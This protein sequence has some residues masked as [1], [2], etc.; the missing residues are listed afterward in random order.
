MRSVLF[1]ISLLLSSFVFSQN[2]EERDRI[3]EKR[4]E[5]I[6]ENIDNSTIDLTTYLEDLY[7]YYDN[8]INLNQTTFD[9]LAKL[10]ILTDNQIYGILNYRQKYGELLTIYELSA[11]EELDD[12]TIEMILPFVSVKKT[13]ISK[14]D[15]NKAISYGKHDIFLRYQ[16]VL[17]TKAGYLDYPDSVLAQSP[18]KKYTGSPDKLYARYRYTYKNNLSW[19][20]TAEKDAGEEFFK[21][22]NKQG[23]DFYSA[24]LM[25]S[26]VGVFQKVVVGDFQANFGQGLT[27]WSGFNMSKTPN[28]LNV[29]RYAKGLKPYTSVNETNFLRG[30]GV[31]L[32]HQFKSKHRVDFTLFGSQK[33]IDANLNLADTIFGGTSESVSSFQT[34][35]LHRTLGEIE[36][37]KV[38]KE[39]IFG[40]AVHFTSQSFK[41]GLVAVSTTY[42]HPL[43]V[44]SQTYNK[45]NFT[46][47]SN[48]SAGLNY[49]YYKGKASFFGETTLSKN[50][51]IATL[52]GI[53]W[54]A[55]PKLDVVFLHRYIDKKNQSLYARP[56]GG[57]T[58][59][60]NGLYI[61]ARAKI[62]KHLNISAYY[63]QFTNAWLK[64]LSDGPSYGR[65]ILV[66]ADYKINYH[67]SF[68]IRLKNKVTQ[69][70]SKDD[71]EGIKPQVFLRKTNLRFHYTQKISSQITLKSRIE[72][73]RFSY[74]K[75]VSKGIM[76]YQ[77]LSY[78]FKTI[79]LK[80][81]G[82]YAIFDTD[83]YD[84]RI[85]AYEN[86][87]LYVFSIP[88][89]FYKGIRTYL[90]AKYEIGQNIDI[91]LRWG[92]YSYANQSELSSGLEKIEGSKKSE[93]KLQIK[94]RL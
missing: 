18:N 17:Q 42:N 24:H 45:F 92:L 30:A 78:N 8:P 66:Q 55:D 22:S 58:S 67:S 35:G 40:G 14:F 19:G 62:S 31:T 44:S 77:D 83:N 68:Y 4:I 47:T 53:T 32:Q 9:E 86:D 48:F 6:G 56:F 20:I 50:N 75:N 94:I 70:N 1:V 71:V 85:Y 15:I 54:H 79:P 34:T 5:F 41:V 81:V 37:E 21:G 25:L 39:S 90:M 36:D 23:F 73:I 87:L 16:R 29:K 12:E 3:I 57:A 28:V 49:S 7:Y 84:T 64:W 88:S 2:D 74:D 26:N 93:V 89:Y 65:D 82:R 52:N 72:L 76:M 63:D 46:G 10:L 80:I 13:E 11:I 59:N 61:G 38:V 69:R 43:Q 33:R 60:E 51:S 91:W 27:M